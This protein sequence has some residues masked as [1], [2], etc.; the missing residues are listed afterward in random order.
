MGHEQVALLR[1]TLDMLVLRTLE[2]GRM[3]GYAIARAIQDVTDEA[4]QVEEGSLYPALYRMEKKD[5]L[6]SEWDKTELNRRARFYE[7]TEEGRRQLRRER[8]AWER[9]IEAVAKVMETA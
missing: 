8:G 9:F 3:H 1:G 5:W 4:L 2:G 7:L 6:R